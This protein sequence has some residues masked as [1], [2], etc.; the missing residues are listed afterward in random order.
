[1][2]IRFS[3]GVVMKPGLEV[4]DLNCLLMPILFN[5]AGFDADADA[6]IGVGLGYEMGHGYAAVVAG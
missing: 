6:D 4:R 5:H 3:D 1:M 2:V